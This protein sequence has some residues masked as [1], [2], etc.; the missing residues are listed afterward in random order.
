MMAAVHDDAEAFGSVLAALKQPVDSD[1]PAARADAVEA[2]YCL[3]AEVPLRA[4]RNAVAILG[5]A[6][7]V[8]EKGNVKAVPDA[9]TAAYLARAALSASAVNVRANASE[10]RD[11]DTAA[12]WLKEVSGLEARAGDALAAVERALRERG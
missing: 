7:V 6:N 2:A 5:L 1:D 12:A 11:R 4:A 3:A 10:I 9:A 8:A